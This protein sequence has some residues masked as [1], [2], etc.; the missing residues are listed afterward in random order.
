MPI[1]ETLNSFLFSFF[2]NYVNHHSIVRYVAV[3]RGKRRKPG[4]EDGKK[5]HS[6]PSRL[7][8]TCV[9]S[10]LVLHHFRL[11]GVAK[12]IVAVFLK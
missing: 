2:Q 6:S 4:N 1:S 3:A 11:F 10:F 9:S 12:Q 8:V 5:S 7:L